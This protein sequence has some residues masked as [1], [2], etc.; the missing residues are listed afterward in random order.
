MSDSFGNGWN[1][2]VFGFR[3]NGTIVGTFGN[4]F[5]SGRTFGPLNVTIPGNITT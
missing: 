1:G 4:G 2:N 3:Q 5:T